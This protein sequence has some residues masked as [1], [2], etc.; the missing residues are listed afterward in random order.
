MSKYFVFYHFTGKEGQGIGNTYIEGVDKLTGEEIVKI[1]E[2]IKQEYKYTHV[3][4]SNII[5]LEE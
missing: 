3:T 2:L 1:E 4:I 5:K